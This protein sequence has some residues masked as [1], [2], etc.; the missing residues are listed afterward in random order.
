MNKKLPN[1]IVVGT[2]KAGTSFLLKYLSQHP[3][4]YLPKTNEI[5]FHSRLEEFSGPY[6]ENIKHKVTGSIEGYHSF[7]D[8]SSVK[9]VVGEI[10]TDYLY[11]YSNSI[12]SIKKHLS[13][14]IKICI[15]LR[16]PVERAFSH[17]KH[18]VSKGHEDM[19]FFDAIKAQKNR[20]NNRWRWAYQYSDVSMYYKQ[21]SAYLAA[22]D[23]VH[24]IIYEDLLLYPE[25]TINSLYRFLN[26]K[27]IHFKNIREKVNVRHFPKYKSIYLASMALDFLEKKTF[28]KSVI[29]P[30]LFELNDKKIR[31]KSEDKSLLIDFFKNDI[32]LLEKKLHIKLNHWYE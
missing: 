4:I 18:M 13:E 7:F 29:A 28:G 21:V 1:F 24:I 5:Y 12:R 30:K 16:N 31:L 10:A 27:P 8:V 15:I 32:K 9:K 3:D 6:D 2:A 22:F 25:I 14:D 11:S 17:Y 26:I 20:K 23:N 19:D